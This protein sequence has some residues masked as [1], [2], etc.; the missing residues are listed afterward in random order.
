MHRI[1]GIFGCAK[2]LLFFWEMMKLEGFF[3]YAEICWYV[4]GVRIAA[5]T[6]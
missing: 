1:V 6:L 4:F 2:V 5:E 3:W